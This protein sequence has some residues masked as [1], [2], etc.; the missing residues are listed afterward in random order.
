MTD[1]QELQTVLE[2]GKKAIQKAIQEYEPTAYFAGFSGGDDSLVATDFLHRLMPAR[3][4]TVHI[5]TGI[6][7]RATRDYVRSMCREQGWRLEEIRAKEDCGQD[8][9][10]IV[11][12]NEKVPGG[13]PGPAAHQPPNSYIYD[14]LKGRAV[15]K[16]HRDWKGQRGNKILLVT[17]IR[18]DESERRMGY[19]DTVIDQDP[20]FP[21]VIWVNPVYYMTAAGRDRYIRERGLRRNPVTKICGT[22]GECLCGAFDEDGQALGELKAQCNLLGE[23]D[24][25]ERILSLQEEVFEEYPWRYDE[26]PPHWFAEAREGQMALEGLPRSDDQNRVA[27]RMCVSCGKQ[28]VQ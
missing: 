4:R 6:G 23:M 15:C 10:E 12:G 1:D 5:N 9:D 25:Y 7:F 16:L 24:R 17:G 21:G 26:R 3:A 18:K 22:S 19:D 8:Y 27:R 28:S 20:A 13:F 14:R 11:R 2:K